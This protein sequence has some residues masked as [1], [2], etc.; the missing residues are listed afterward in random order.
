MDIHT[1]Q[2]KSLSLNESLRK[3]DM[4]CKYPVLVFFFISIL[5]WT[6]EIKTT[7]FVEAN[8]YFFS[9]NELPFWFY[10]NT[11]TAINSQSNFSSQVFFKANYSLSESAFLET[12]IS[13]LYRDGGNTSFQRNDLYVKF[14]NNWLQIS[15][16]ATN[17]AEKEAG[18][19]MTNKNFIWSNN[20][21][22]IPGLLFASSNPIQILEGLGINWEIGNY[23]LNDSRYV[24]NTMIHYKR[25][26]IIAKLDE[27]NTLSASL[28]HVAQWG[29]TSP[30]FGKLPRDASAFIK[31]F[32]AQKTSTTGENENALGNHIG[33]FLLDYTYSTSNGT[34]NAYYDHPFE[35]GSGSRFAN[36]PDGLWGVAYKFNNTKYIKQVLYEFATTTNQS[37]NTGISGF[38]NYFSNNLYRNGWSYDD[39]II[40]LPFILYDKNIE[41]NEINSPIISNRV[42]VHHLGLIGRVKNLYWKLKTSYAKHLGT[43]RQPFETPLKIWS[44][45]LWV[46]Y[47]YKNVGT[48]KGMVGLDSSNQVSNVGVGVGYLYS[49]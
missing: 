42:Q 47:A 44:S 24:S 6:Q 20:A 5:G 17:P 26:E 25:L 28:Q 34:L 21:R 40:G 48:L 37:G 11:Q 32:F 2:K 38:D 43:Y 22:A 23:F 8:A 45:G 16:G 39:Q 31:V 15:A 27:R 9:E 30:E 19:S 35:D 13:A 41:V 33:S 4:K 36:F 14:T 7:G 18:L 1:Q 3:T 46:S 10:T 49:F 12:G 29:G